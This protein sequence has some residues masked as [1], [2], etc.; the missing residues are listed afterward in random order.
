[1]EVSLF[2]D[3]NK[4]KIINKLAENHEDV[5]LCKS[6]RYLLEITLD[7]Q[8]SDSESLAESLDFSIEKAQK[9]NE[10]ILKSNPVNLEEIKS[11]L[12]Q[13]EKISSEVALNIEKINQE[14]RDLELKIQN[15]NSRQIE[16]IH[17]T[18]R[19]ADNFFEVETRS[20]VIQEELEYLSSIPVLLR[21]FHIRVKEKVGS[22]NGLRLGRLDHL[23]IPWEEINA[24][25]GQCAFLLQ[26]VLEVKR[27]KSTKINLYPLGA[28]SRISYKKGDDKRYQLFFS[29]CNYTN[30]IVGFNKAQEIFLELVDETQNMLGD[31]G[32]P[33]N[34][35]KGFI[36]GLPLR[37]EPNYKERWTQAL[38]FLLQDLNYLLHK[39]L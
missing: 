4:Q 10:E 32:A 29:D 25:W 28:F 24:G 31:K 35:E 27:L 12:T 17:H 36:G 39:V 30:L 37:F 8:I 3:L 7:K 22:I 33:Y 23:Q 18:M 2:E 1:M 9:M 11:D 38:M 13:I 6:C 19:R 15:H 34:I 5:I 21:V 20:K 16:E 26:T 14:I